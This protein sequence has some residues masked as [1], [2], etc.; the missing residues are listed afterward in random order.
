MESNTEIMAKG[1]RVETQSSIVISSK[2]QRMDINRPG[3]TQIITEHKI[4]LNLL[5][6]HN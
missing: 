2:T 1:V 3:M 6:T 5:Q 4:S